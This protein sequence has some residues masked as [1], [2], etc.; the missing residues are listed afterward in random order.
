M[1]A[2]IQHILLIE[3]NPGDTRLLKEFLH[4]ADFPLIKLECGNNSKADLNS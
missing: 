2:T 3:D 1:E 4:E